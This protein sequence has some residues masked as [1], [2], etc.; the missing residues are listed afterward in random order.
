MVNIWKNHEGKTLKILLKGKK[1]NE[2][3]EG[4][5]RRKRKG[6]R[7]GSTDGEMEQRIWK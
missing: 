7:K 6:R 2:N 1:G 5:G 3:E 4:D